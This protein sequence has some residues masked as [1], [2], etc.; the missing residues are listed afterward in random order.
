MDGRETGE[1]KGGLSSTCSTMLTGGKTRART[2]SGARIITRYLRVVWA[3]NIGEEKRNL[4]TIIYVLFVGVYKSF[5]VA[6]IV[7]R[8]MCNMI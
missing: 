5:S 7:Q 2:V 6:I 1:K 3:T 4:Y 8:N